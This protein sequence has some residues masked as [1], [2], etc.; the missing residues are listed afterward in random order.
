MS[1]VKATPLEL[2][3]LE[4]GTLILTPNRRLSA[5]LRRDYN[6]QMAEQ[7]AYSWPDLQALP[8]D[9]WLQL[10]YEA[11]ALN[12]PPAPPLPALISSRQSRW[13]WRRV[14]SD[15]LEPGMDLEG[16]VVA[17]QEAR[18]LVCRWRL[19]EAD[20]YNES[21][22]ESTLFA[23]AHRDYLNQLQQR[24]WADQAAL[25]A[26]ICTG[27]SPG[28]PPPPAVCLHGFN[29]PDEP[30]LQ[31]LRQLFT[32]TGIPVHCTGQA[33]LQGR[34]ATVEFAT[35]QD[36]FRQALCWALA[37]WHRQ[38]RHRIGVVVPNLQ[39][40]RHH[41]AAV[42]RDLAA[43]NPNLI[44]GSWHD[45][46]NITA[47]QPLAEYPLCSHLLLWLNSL[48]PALPLTH[49]E[50]LLKSPFFAGGQRQFQHRDRFIQWLRQH[51]R[52]QLA[53]FQLPA[54][55]Q[56]FQEQ[57]SNPVEAIAA[58]PPL[59]L[60]AGLQAGLGRQQSLQQWLLWL[61]QALD[62]LGFLQERTLDSA[63]YQVQQ[64]LLE[65]MQEMADLDPLLGATGFQEFVAELRAQL[66][67]TPFQPQTEAA[68]IQVMGSL[69]AAALNFDALWVC[70]CHSQQWPQPPVG[71]PFLPR[72]V[73]RRHG[74]PGS[75]PERE[76]EYASAMLSGF[77]QAAP[78]V[79]FS[80]GRQQGDAQLLLSPLLV[81]LPATAPPVFDL[82]PNTR[83]QQLYELR[84]GIEELA[85]D[86]SGAPLP[87]TQVSGGSGLI[88]SQSQ[89]PFRA[90][91]EYRLGLQAPDQLQDGVR[92]SDRGTLVHWV[93]EAFWQQVGSRQQL[94]SLLAN[95]DSL[96]ACLASILTRQLQRFRQQVYL[97][98][99]ALYELER[100]RTLQV[101]TAWLHSAET[102]RADFAVD[103]I[104]KRQTLHLGGLALNLTVD[105]VDRL[106]DGSRVIVDYKTGNK[107]TSVWL[108]QRP[109]EPQLPL[110]ALLD[111]VQPQGI[112][113]GIVRPDKIQWQGLQAKETP[114]SDAQLKTVNPPAEGWSGQVAAWQQTLTAIA[115]EYRAGVASVTP[116]NTSVCQ[117][118]H[119][120]PV[121]RIKELG[122]VGD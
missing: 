78:E 122:D 45:T 9:S 103:T 82:C 48:G 34:A 118:C 54:L 110:Y 101:V 5:W 52:S 114:F 3:G 95:E 41:L 37:H 121:C 24:N 69:E 81:E 57:D 68:P 15:R 33:R 26:L 1:T 91:A 59:S 55:W 119:L 92:P 87:G 4:P 76:L 8:L 36:Q 97:F 116:I 84:S 61:H 113:F 94:L 104:E 46:I 98:P 85:A 20:W 14:L 13:L 60:P 93:L 63:G 58:D 117:H 100:L 25:S 29:D 115:E 83:E 67:N 71:N 2:H 30:Q 50:V 106:A 40:Q 32:D 7:G 42:S 88:R 72:S 47:G 62:A 112:Y 79:V 120:D 90:Y 23:G 28:L 64:R 70:E 51:N 43:T 53:A 74:M 109:E 16:T 65:A 19:P 6:Q 22:P 73:L 21:T 99:E 108:G 105:R 31:R 66:Q 86:D 77:R 75:G 18:R 27:G 89:C 44:P 38:P 17:C 49:W 39:A 12:P 96:Q 10:R 111:A 35:H 107:T 56:R 11:L 80:W 102:L